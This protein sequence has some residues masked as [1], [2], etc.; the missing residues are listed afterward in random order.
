MKRFIIIGIVIVLMVGALGVWFTTT[1]PSHADDSLVREAVTVERG[2]IVSAVKATGR[3]EPQAEVSLGFETNGT[4][5]EVLVERGQ[6]VRVGDPLAR[7]ETNELLLQLAQ[8]EANL[9][10]VQAGARAEDIAA[11]EAALQSTQANFDKIAAGTRVEDIAAAEASLRGARANY[12][13]LA[14]GPD[15]DE[16]TVAAANLR[17][18]EVALKN[19]QW[20]YDEIA[21]ADNVGESPQAAELERATINYESALANYRLAV[22]GASDGQLEAGWAQVEQAQ[23]QL[24]KLRNGPTPEELAIAQ[25]QVDQAEAQLE[26]LKNGPASEELAIA[27]NQVD[28]ARLRLEHATLTAPVNGIVTEV[29][30]SVGERPGTAAVILM[31]DLSKLHIDLPVDEIDLPSVAVSQPAI[32]TLDALPDSPLA[33]QV[34]TIAPAP[35]SSGGSVTSYEVTVTLDDQDEKARVGMTANVS[36]ETDRREHV[37]IIPAHLVQVDKKSGQTYVNKVLPDGQAVRTEV[38]LGLRSGQDIE[39]LSGLEV[40][41][42]VL[43]RVTSGQ[44]EAVA[45]GEDR[46]LFG[47]IQSMHDVAD[48]SQIR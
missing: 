7:L 22:Q 3:L 15:D 14:E 1:Q 38:M 32:I 28:Q 31:A 48:Q 25:S 45:S 18:T 8:A 42:Q 40:S 17:T 27:Q 12:D 29:N 36:I 26:K 34:T 24:D 13:D 11:A 39:V 20:A 16:I 44:L 9:A 43:A 10:Q 23:A 33:G 19:A 30:K 5:A 6:S 4:V 21:Y 41:D 35:T 37:V 47:R 46:G 2:T